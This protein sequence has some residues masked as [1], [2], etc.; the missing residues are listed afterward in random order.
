MDF[1]LSGTASGRPASAGLT[2]R[3]A[4]SYRLTAT[5]GALAVDAVLR[6][7]VPP[8]VHFACDVLDPGTVVR[9][10]RAR[11]TADLRLTGAATGA[12]QVEEGVL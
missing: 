3:A 12:D 1:A 10:L 5:V 6:A 7:Q 11:G 2:L 4:S 9:H 8:G